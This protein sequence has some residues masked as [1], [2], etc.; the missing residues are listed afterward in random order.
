MRAVVVVLLLVWLVVAVLGVLLEGLAW[1][2]V[3]GLLLFAAT[4]AWGWFKV[5]AVV[6]RD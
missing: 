5:R 1:L 6:G 2:L 4:A 3:L